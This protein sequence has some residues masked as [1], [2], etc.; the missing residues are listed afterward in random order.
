MSVMIINTNSPRFYSDWHEEN[1]EKGSP[2][3]QPT[4]SKLISF[5]SLSLCVV[6]RLKNLCKS[7]SL[8]Y[9]RILNQI[10]IFSTNF[11]LFVSFETKDLEAITI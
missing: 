1:R 2:T 6:E 3:G 10:S 7:E 8:S 4:H 5:S 9:W 11:I